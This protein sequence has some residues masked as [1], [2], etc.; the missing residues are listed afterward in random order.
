MS[1]MTQRSRRDDRS[2][3]GLFERTIFSF[4]GPPQLGDQKVREGYVADESANLCHKCGE[5]WD[6]H[7][8]VNTGTFAYRR[9]AVTP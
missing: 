1:A 3:L 2:E 6:S 7:E 9:C 8:R 4:M 5:H